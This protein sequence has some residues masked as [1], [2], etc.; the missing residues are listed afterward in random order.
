[1]AYLRPALVSCLLI[2]VLAPATALADG[3]K[4][5]NLNPFKRTKAPATRRSVSDDGG[6]QLP[7]PSMP[8]MEMPKMPKLGLGP[9]SKKSSGPSTFQRINN[10]TKAVFS[11][12]KSTLMPWTKPKAS[13]SDR[14]SFRTARSVSDEKKG[15][16]FPSW[17]SDREDEKPVRSPEDFLKQ[18]RVMPSY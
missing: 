15:S 7:K 9:Q 2:A 18:P 3:W 5:P 4:F 12:T 17:F 6:F 8:K 14:P 13:V 16:F 1:M 11:K 10:G